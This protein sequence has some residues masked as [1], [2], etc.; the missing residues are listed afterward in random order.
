M[1]DALELSQAAEK[2][3]PQPYCEHYSLCSVDQFGDP[4]FIIVTN[5]NGQWCSSAKESGI[6][7]VLPASPVFKLIKKPNVYKD[8]DGSASST[9]LEPVVTSSP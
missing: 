5:I 9:S 1:V 6:C 2:F 7:L 3:I 4:D 8:I